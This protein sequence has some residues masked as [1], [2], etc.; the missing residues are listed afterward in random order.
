VNSTAGNGGEQLGDE[1]LDDAPAQDTARDAAHGGEQPGDDASLLSNRPFL[2]LLAAR[3]LSMMGFVFAPVALAFGILAMPGGEAWMISAV[4]GAQLTPEV[5]LALFGGVIADRY[6]RAYVMR[7]GLA[8]SGI[9][10]LT[11]GGMMVLG[12]ASVWAMCLAAALTGL[13]AAVVY[14]ALTGIIPDLVPRTQL[15]QANAWLG[16]GGSVARLTGLVSAGAVVVALGGGW[17]LVCAAG[18]Y[19][20]SAVLALWLPISR[21]SLARG[22]RV[23]RQLVEG[24]VEFKSRQWLWV[25]VCE[26]GLLIMAFEAFQG[27]LGPLIAVEELPGAIVLGTRPLAGEMVWT[28]ILAGE[29]L[30]AIVGVF[31][32]LVWRPA[33]PILVGA[34][35]TLAAVA[36]PVLLGVGAHAWVVIGSAALMGLGFEIFGVLYLTTLQ[37]EIPPTLLSRVAAYDAFGSMVLAPVGAIVAAPLAT[38]LGV[39][40]AMMWA[41]AL[42]LVV[43]VAAICSPGVRH[44]RVR[45]LPGSGP[46]VTSPGPAS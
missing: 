3:T 7:A 26:S 36:P 21:D 14:P 44:L 17:A 10:W 4:L 35:L 24:W 30:G 34:V 25:V 5:L 15:Q 23:L 19:L 29:A 38:W 40:P 1:Q 9:G 11:L 43:T 16:M 12:P 27:V 13:A 28:L 42:V 33:R 2:L 31:I 46:A 6:P 32:S 8:V 20:I 22:E 39:R 18:L 41:G 37:N 45:P